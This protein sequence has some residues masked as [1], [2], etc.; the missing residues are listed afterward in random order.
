[1]PMYLF[2]LAAS[3]LE[4]NG[5]LYC[6]V[7]FVGFRYQRDYSMSYALACRYLMLDHFLEDKAYLIPL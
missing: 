5:I 1:M 4:Q 6:A 7:C 3:I 2:I